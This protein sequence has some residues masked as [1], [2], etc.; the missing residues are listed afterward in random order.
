MME[1]LEFPF[2]ARGAYQ[3]F[4]KILEKRAATEYLKYFLDEKN[5]HYLKT[6]EE[7]L[8]Q[9]FKSND[10]KTFARDTSLGLFGHIVEKENGKVLD[11]WMDNQLY[12]DHIIYKRLSDIL[13]KE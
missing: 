12:G 9:W 10:Y 8:K 7:F 6:K 5:P 13:S 3:E 2:T 1:Q 11:R 4:N